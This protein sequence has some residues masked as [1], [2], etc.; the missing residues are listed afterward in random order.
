MKINDRQSPPPVAPASRKSA[1]RPSRPDTGPA[2]PADRVSLSP[3]AQRLLQSNLDRV[4]AIKARVEEGSYKVDLDE[5]AS[6][7]VNKELP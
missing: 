7:I 2:T 4:A 5:L 1:D 6:A 3:E